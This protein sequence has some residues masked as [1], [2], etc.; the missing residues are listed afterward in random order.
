M[1][2]GEIIEI[3]AD[4]SLKVPESPE[5]PFIEGDGIGPESDR[6]SGMRRAR[7]STLPFKNLMTAR[8]KFH[9]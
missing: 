3:Q 7:S 8:R 6:I 1:A 9:G 5:I 2:N 4:G